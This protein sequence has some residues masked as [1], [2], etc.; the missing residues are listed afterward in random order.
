MR[1][2]YAVGAVALF[3][4]PA[5][6]GV[7]ST[8]VVVD[9]SFEDD[10]ATPLVNGQEINPGEEFGELFTIS[11]PTDRLSIFDS[12]PDGPNAGGGD[13]DL[14][15]GLG[16]ILIPQNP[17]LLAQSTP[18]IFDTPNDDAGSFTFMFDFVNPTEFASLTLIDIDSGGNDAVVIT[19]TDDSGDVR[20]YQVASGFSNDVEVS[21]MGF[22]LLDLQDVSEQVGEG[23]GSAIVTRDDAGYD[24]E[25]IVNATIDFSTSGGID[26]IAINSFVPTPGAVGLFAAAGA[27][28][29]RRR[30][31]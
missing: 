6:A 25:R 13:E 27:V 17:S 1:F 20:I 11:S 4:A 5:V 10:L 23:G 2:G 9:F 19:L 26:N 8:P 12:T 14:L 31:A 28:S 7:I 29:L 18:D 24:P 21:P 30:R 3:C 22:Q 15:V 16:N